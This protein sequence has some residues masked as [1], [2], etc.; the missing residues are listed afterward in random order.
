MI[1]YNFMH[2]IKLLV[3]VYDVVFHLYKSDN[4]GSSF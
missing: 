4:V 3:L 1:L 2:F